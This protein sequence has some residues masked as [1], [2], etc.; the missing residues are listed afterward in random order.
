MSETWSVAGI[1]VPAGRMVRHS[2]ELVELP[3]PRPENG[4]VVVRMVVAGVSPRDNTIRAR[5]YGCGH[6]RAAA[7]RYR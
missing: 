5:P 2:L 1:A 6:A 7:A 4:T 3:D